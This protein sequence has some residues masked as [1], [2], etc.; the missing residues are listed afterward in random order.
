M[1]TEQKVRNVHATGLGPPED[2][3]S[4]QQVEDESYESALDQRDMK[5]LGKRPELKRR[6]RFAS[7]VGY[8]IVLGLTW[9]FTLVT[10]VFS[11]ANGGTAGAIWLTFVVC[12]GMGTCVL[13][14]AE[15]ASMAP[16]SGGQYHWVSEFAPPRLQKQLS[17]I[18]G[19]L[20]ALGWQAAMPTVAYIGAQQVTGLIAVCDPTYVIQ[21]WHGAL[22]TMAFV[23]AAIFFNTF[24]IGKL[25]LL[26]AVA[27]FL[28]L[29]GFLIFI[30]I[31]WVKGP[32]ADA[33]ATFTEFEDGNG[34]GS[35]GLATLIAIVGPATTYLGGDSAVHLS[36]ELKDASYVL[37]RAMVS[38]AAINYGLG[39]VT[40]ITFVSNL[41]NIDVDLASATGQPYI[42][43]IQAITGSKAAAIVLTVIMIIMFFFC[44]VN[45]VT[46][47]S[48]QIFAFARDK[49]L[50]FHVFLS[51]VRPGSGVPANSIYVT[52]VVTCL[53]AL[54]IIGSTTA[55]N[56]ILSV[57]STGLFTSYLIV[58]SCM[59]VKRLRGEAFPATQFSLGRFGIPINMIA[60]AFLA[61]AF[62][63][64]F[65]PSA[66][67]P[68]PASMNWAIL[69][70][71]A[72]ILFAGGYYLVRGKD[73]YDGPVHYVRWQAVQGESS[74]KIK[75]YTQD[76][77]PADEEVEL[78]NF[79]GVQTIVDDE[80]Q[81]MS[82]PPG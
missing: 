34:W 18:V 75:T 8:V 6:F 29:A 12:C 16:T 4:L 61:L 39:F 24:L 52:L 45:Q 17:Y 38:A 36:E 58:I 76:L 7:I 77:R 69:I 48:R 54:V 73:E 43:V 64:L 56:I 3:S 62:V 55:F 79:L 20:C 40:M 33:K 11:L 60:I 81:Q 67:N 5:R 82:S 74:Q 22:L 2:D 31:I 26:E 42:A 14:M 21:G 68:D 37:P 59:L 44:A 30:V 49:G 53:I 27:V 13:S 1:E 72:V 66:P 9:E 25:P 63:F 47:S 78:L 46:T 10:S 65:F 51:R 35:V 23:L 80:A 19:W 41:G 70:Y 71:G 15:M 28:H 57:S 32:K 50:P